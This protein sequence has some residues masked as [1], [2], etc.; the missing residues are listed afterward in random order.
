MKNEE[1]YRDVMGMVCRE[2]RVAEADVTRSNREECA[3][4]RFLLVLALSKML[5]DNEISMLTGITR[6]GVCGI[7]QRAE[8]MKKWTVRTNWEAIWNELGAKYLR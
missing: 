8:K 2:T 7:R 4:A 1:L 5:T 6:R 3:D